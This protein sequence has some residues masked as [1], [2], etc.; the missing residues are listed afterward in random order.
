MNKRLKKSLS[1]FLA[2]SII[3][4]SFFFTSIVNGAD[5]VNEQDVRTIDFWADPDSVLTDASQVKVATDNGKSTVTALGLVQAHTIVNSNNEYY[6]FLPT[7]ADLNALKLYFTAQSTTVDGTPIQNGAATNIFAGTTYNTKHTLVMDYSSYNLYVVKSDLV[8]TVYINTASGSMQTVNE[9][10]NHVAYET[11]SIKVVN[12]NGKV[13]YLG[14]LDKISGHGNGTFSTGNNKNSYNIKLAQSTSLLGLSKGKKWVLLSGGNDRYSTM[15]KNRVTY[16]FADYIGIKYQSGVQ[17]VDLYCEGHYM[18]SYQLVDKPEIKSS[19]VDVVDSYENL[20]IANGKTDPVTGVFTPADF[21]TSPPSVKHR[22]ASTG[23]NTNLTGTASTFATGI[24]NYHYSSDLVNPS[25]ITGGYIFEIEISER[26]VEEN[27]GF[28]SYNRQGWT[29]AKSH[30]YMTRE[31]TEYCY[32]LLYALGGAVYNSGTVPNKQ[33]KNTYRAGRFIPV[34]I[35]V[36]NPAPAVEYQGKKWSDLLDANSAVLYYWTQ[37]YFKNMDSSTSSTYFYKDSDLVDGKIYAGPIWDMDQTIGFDSGK[38]EKRWGSSYTSPDGWY[39]KNT[40]IYRFDPNDS[41]TDY[42]S[43]SSVPRSFY[44]ALATNCTDFWAMAEDYWYNR[45]KPATQILL[46]NAPDSGRL[47]SMDWYCNE[48][49]YSGTMNLV[50]F[51]GY[52]TSPYDVN[53]TKQNYTNWLSSRNTWIDSQIPTRSINGAN[54]DSIPSQ[55]YTGSE[56]TPPVNVT[57]NTTALGTQT[58]EEGYDYTLDYSDNVEVGAAKVA[59][60][61][62]NRYAGTSKTVQ[63]NIIPSAITTGTLYIPEFA[64]SGSIVTSSLSDANGNAVRSGVTYQWYRNGSAIDGATESTYTVAPEDVGT[65]LTL[66][67]TG[68]GSQYTGTIQSNECTVKAGERPGGITRSIASWNYDYTLNAS[69]LA[70]ADQTGAKYYYNATS[71]DNQ[72]VSELYASVNA[73]D[74]AEVKWSGSADL[75]DNTSNSVLSDQ[76][77]VMGTSK[78]NSLA[79]GQYPY[80]ETVTSTTGYEKITFT[81]KLGGTKKAPRDWKLQYSLDGVSFIDVPDASYSIVSNKNMETAFDNVSL[82]AECDNQVKVYIRIVGTSDYQIS[83]SLGIFGS[84]SGDAAINNVVVK[85]QSLDIVTKLYAPTMSIATGSEIFSDDLIELTDNNGGADIYYTITSNDVTTEPMLYTEPF[86]PFKAE[87][88]RRGDS[89]TVKAYSSYED[90][91]S[92]NAEA[93]YTYAGVN[94]VSF[95]YDDYSQNVVGG[96]L[97]SNGGVY[98]KSAYM[99]AYADGTTQYVPLFNADNKAYSIAPDDGLKW[100]EDSGF[101]FKLST[102]GYTNSAFSCK[103]YTTTSGPASATL[104]Y[105][106]DGSEYKTIEQNKSLPANGILENYYYNYSLPS[107]CDN[108]ETLYIRLVTTQDLTFGLT[109]LHNNESKGNLYINNIVLSGDDNGEYK[110]PYT[111]KTTDYF[112][113]NGTV[114]YFSPSNVAMQF[115]VSNSKGET[116]M[117]G[118]YPEL[119]IQLSLASDFNPADSE[120][121]TVSVWAG[122]DD[123]RS[124]VNKRTYYYKGATISQFKY[125]DD[126]SFSQYLGADGTYVNANVGTGTL[127]MYPNGISPTVLD[128]TGTYGVKAAWTADNKFTAT[129]NLDN[130]DGNGFWLITTSTKNYRNISVNLDQLSSNSGPRDWGIAYSTDGVNYTYVENSNVRAISN[131]SATKPVETYG[132]LKLPEECENQETLYIKVF[133]NGG[134]CVSGNELELAGKGN[135]GINAIEISGTATPITVTFKATVLESLTATEGTH[136]VANA[137]AVINGANYTADSDGIIEISVL[138]GSAITATFNNGYFSR[139]VTVAAAEDGKEYNVPLMIFDVTGDS[140]VNMRDY[141]KLYGMVDEDTMKYYSPIFNSFLNT[142]ASDFEYAPLSY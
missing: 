71:G 63:F 25:D 36:T 74:S 125:N 51:Y 23:T 37:E 48:I 1:V 96:K 126:L 14:G 52:G 103:A 99:T 95:K 138:P 33:V 59:V 31:M 89:V 83:G 13:D 28:C 108:R 114:K 57:F 64:Y 113:T 42:S 98:D 140:I 24:G 27:T 19:R 60:N 2:L 79:W 87:T 78:T 88:A 20:E 35:N 54:I 69:A 50:R 130:P 18:G 132:N 9:S 67:V 55:T 77:P 47:H 22:L 119:G 21:S 82:P 142:L 104:Q 134:E 62:I 127:Q 121:Y 128:R 117:S 86:S 68:N 120:P 137:S 72:A 73:T 81:A 43:D 70:N 100:T 34:T 32:D 45:V 101:T 30:D 109:N 61:G 84:M 91:V 44:G 135:T 7:T 112:G 115:T 5:A 3:L 107:E 111:N 123:D 93:T 26:W 40:R 85:G 129:K 29:M 56:I 80:F 102:A 6:L 118:A 46:G 136:P 8:G 122:D 76:A 17:P 110:M 133:I 53:A 139:T 92:D 39:T 58:L 94:I 105:S 12:A 11:G 49:Q 90:I 106:L 75:Y 65:V 124:P 38:D 116:V 4:S 66:T 41:S 131:D 10:S 141:S 16:D 15:L 97:F